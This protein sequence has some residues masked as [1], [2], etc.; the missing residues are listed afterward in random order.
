MSKKGKNEETEVRQVNTDVDVE[1]AYYN[2]DEPVVYETKKPSFLKKLFRGKKKV[3]S[4][5][6]LASLLTAVLPIS[7]TNA[8]KSAFLVT[9]SVSQ[10]TSTIA[11]LLPST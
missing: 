9:K 10:F 1:N 11:A 8:T 7:S 6:D 2:Y 3:T 4:S 5:N